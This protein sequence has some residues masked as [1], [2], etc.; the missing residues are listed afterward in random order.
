MKRYQII[1]CS[2]EGALTAEYH[3]RIQL[4]ETDRYDEAKGWLAGYVRF[5][6]LKQSGYDYIIIREGLDQ[7]SMFDQ[8]GWTHY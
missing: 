3:D 5:D 4:H 2:S 1:G 7:R 6:G 8:S